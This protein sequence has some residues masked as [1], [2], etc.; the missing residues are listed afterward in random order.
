MRRSTWTL[1]L[2]VVLLAGCGRGSGS[3]DGGKAL[4]TPSTVAPLPLGDKIH[5]YSA[6][7]VSPGSPLPDVS[8]GAAT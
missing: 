5:Q 1:S 2:L 6:A 8:P 4:S 3:L 7:A